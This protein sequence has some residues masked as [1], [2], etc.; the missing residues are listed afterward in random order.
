MLGDRRTTERLRA[1]K[2]AQERGEGLATKIQAGWW[3]YRY[4]GA[5]LPAWGEGVSAVQC[6]LPTYCL[7]Q[8]SST[9]VLGRLMS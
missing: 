6:E 9:T 4:G 3:G 5:G 1:E 2:L 7:L 8:A